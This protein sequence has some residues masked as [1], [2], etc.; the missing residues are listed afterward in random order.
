MKFIS[1]I[2][3]T[4][5]L[6]NTILIKNFEKNFAMRLKPLF[7]LLVF[8]IAACSAPQPK[9]KSPMQVKVDQF[10]PFTLTSNIDDLS[11]N[12]KEMLKI[13]FRVSEIMD[14]L[15]WQQ[16]FGAKEDALALTDDEASKQFITINYGPWER[17]DGNASFI[18]GIDEKPLGAQ[19][20]PEDMT[21][22]E[23]EK[24]EADDK[25]SLY[26]ILERNE[27]GILVT[28]P[29]SKAYEAELKE[30]SEL[31]K[32][33]SALAE[34]PGFKKYLELRSEALL[35]DEYLASDLAWM[36]MK[37]NRI[38][39]VVGPIENYEDRLYNYK[40]AF[41]AYILLKDLDWSKKLDR[42]AGL[43]PELQ[44]KLPVAPEYKAEEPGTNSDLGAY[45]V[46]YYAGDCNAGSKTI[47]I[48]LP[49]DP[50]V[51]AEKGSRRL[52]L[53][54]A[55]QAKYE[56]ILVPITETLIDPEQ[57]MHV[58]FDAFFENTM[59]HEVAHGIGVHHTITTGESVRKAMKDKSSALEEGKADILGIFL[60]KEL[61]DM[62]ELDTDLM[63]NY[64]T[65]TAGIFRSVRFGASSAHGVANLV[66]YNYFKEKEAFT[67]SDEGIYTIDP[68]KML[69]A[70]NELTNIILTIQGDG[71][72]EAAV[73]LINKYGVE[74]ED[75]KADLER[76]NKKGIPVDI[77]FSQGIE[78]AGI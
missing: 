60:V 35:T 2:T 78:Q 47:A 9:T 59:L 65:F 69:I 61:I 56:K 5:Y 71:D 18:E 27:E 41:E 55:M 29:Y 14:E 34:D 67:R 17:L 44:K 30:A 40:A 46:I 52:Q 49:N 6:F 22:E 73:S 62:G 4:N 66:R 77:V 19:F 43:L 25:S 31:L 33:A 32:K 75:L 58:T 63:N 21:T 48:N 1:I 24:F 26:T 64:V 68:E 42:Y 70:I 54:N 7:Y 39:F 50:K 36:D 3:P 20:Y 28:V 45:D 53:K 8:M 12:Q 74:K 38:D 15:F 76:I 16:S 13:F 23:F 51:H 37:T 72:Y 10:A 57:Q 11:E